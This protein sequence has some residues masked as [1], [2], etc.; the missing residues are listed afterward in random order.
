MMLIKLS[1]VNAAKNATMLS[2]ESMFGKLFFAVFMLLAAFA[3]L[4]VF[5]PLASASTWRGDDL[6]SRFSLA[7]W[8]VGPF[9]IEPQIVLSDFGYDSNIYTQP[10]AVS[11]YSFTAG[12]Q[13]NAFLTFGRK[14]FLSFSESPRYVY[15]MHTTRERTWN[16]YL[17][18]SLS[19]LLNRF[20][21]QLG[22]HWIDA[23]Q[24]LNYEIDIRPRLND[25][26]Y[27]ASILWQPTRRTSFELAL[28]QSR[29]RYE[30][31]ID[32]PNRIAGQLDRNQKILNF[33][34][35]NQLTPRTRA[36]L[37]F[38]YGRA[39]FASPDNPRESLSY[40][41]YGGFVFSTLGRVNGRIRLGYKIYHPLVAGIADY[42]GLVG[43]SDISVSLFRS[44][45]LR[46][47]Y[48]RDV[49][50]SISFISPYFIE[51]SYGAGISYYFLR[52][53]F[54]LDYDYSQLR[55]D[56]PI[57]GAAPASGARGDRIFMNTVGLFFRIGKSVG[58]GIRAGHYIRSIN[59]YGLNIN[60]DFVG[61][62]LTYEF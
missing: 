57:M 12:P 1:K 2:F 25:T 20:F 40:A 34:I 26:G 24:R 43:D 32:D 19:F 29:Y 41:G 27:D 52:R 54:R 30:N 50:F 56:Y 62:N 48:R 35:F 22:A 7:P 44:F 42:R 31:P 36:F 4:A 28:H 14:I 49:Q 39:N 10:N 21:I 33:T 47:S 5:P 45:A 60:R 61:L 46:G 38:E 15:Y 11:D 59:F 16:N 58:I 18:G 13:I 6:L 9:R 53:R 17:N 8:K 3:S 51:E 37:D 55:Y 23:R